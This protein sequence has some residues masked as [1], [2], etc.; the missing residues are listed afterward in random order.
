[1]T[2]DSS[3]YLAKQFQGVSGISPNAPDSARPINGYLVNKSQIEKKKAQMR[4]MGG[5]DGPDAIYEISDED[6]FGDGLTAQGEIEV[7]LRPEMSGRTSYLK[8]DPLENGGRPVSMN[9]TNNDDIIDAIINSDGEDKKERMTKAVLD[10][11]KGYVK[12]DFSSVNE[13]MIDPKNPENRK[14]EHF[15]ALVSGGFSKNDIEGIHYPY[16]KVHELSRMIDISDVVNEAVIRSR[17]QK[18]NISQMQINMMYDDI[19]EMVIDSKSYSQL[20]DYRAAQKVRQTYENSGI[21]YIKF[22]HPMGFN[23]E[24]PRYY[25]QAANDFERTE[26]VIK[27]NIFK[28]IDEIIQKVSKDFYKK[29]GKK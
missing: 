11:L 19:E 4:K 9:S 18:M 1:M 26:E 17:A 14:H 13:G 25:D 8:G 27:R 29:S 20:K 15:E 3:K 24:S 23:I 7:V 10:I 22:A 5:N 16:S 6:I 2:E 28:E 21:G 12:Q